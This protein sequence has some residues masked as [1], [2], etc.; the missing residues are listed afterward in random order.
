MPFDSS[1]ISL[2]PKSGLPAARASWLSDNGRAWFLRLSELPLVP[3]FVIMELIQDADNKERGRKA[4]KLIEPLTVVWP[5]PTQCAQALADF[6]QLHLSHGLGLLDS[7][8]AACAVGHSATLLT[9]NSKHYRAIN[10]LSIEQLYG[11]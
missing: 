5:T 2:I 1:G 11:R 10:G 9:F 3:G 4:M 8:I 7:L 6:R